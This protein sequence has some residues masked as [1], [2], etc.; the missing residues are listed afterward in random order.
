[1]QFVCKSCNKIYPVDTYEFKCPCGGLF[2]LDKQKG[3]AINTTVSLGE[4]ETPVLKR[5]IDGVNLFLKLD[6]LMPTGSFKDRGAFTLINHA[7][8]IGIKEVVEDSSGNAASSISAYC[9]AAGIKCNIYISKNT[10]AGKV[11]QMTAYGA[12]IIQIDGNRD[13]VAK[14]TLEAAENTY[15]ASHVYNPIFYEGTK[16]LALELDKQV[17]G[18]DWFVVPVGN[19]TMLI[20]AYNAYKEL[21]RMPKILAVQSEHCNPVYAAFHNIGANPVTPTVA[22]GIAVGLPMRK[23]ELVDII[24]ESGGTVI[25]VDDE[26]VNTA[27][28]RLSLMG[29]Y[30]EPTSAS[31]LAG[32]LKYF[33]KD[34]AAGLKIVLPLTGSGLKKG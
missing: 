25:T 13:D 9:A 32:A 21:G 30:C 11:K 26:S 6:Y 5:T 18:L 23:N 19:G 14:A 1:M 34:N 10:S 8:N 3:E 15:Y 31:I 4:M 27:N 24:K 7:K 33:N 28:E 17:G 20:G 22:E 29:I 12:N 2:S 16:S